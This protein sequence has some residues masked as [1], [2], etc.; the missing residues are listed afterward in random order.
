[1]TDGPELSVGKFPRARDRG[2]EGVVTQQGGADHGHERG[3]GP[4]LTATGV[5]EAL[6][7]SRRSEG[8]AN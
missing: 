7:P 6:R 2:D 3:S 8:G 1:M 4:D 5:R